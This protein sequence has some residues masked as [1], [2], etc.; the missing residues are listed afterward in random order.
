MFV[1]AIIAAAVTAFS[2]TCAYDLPDEKTLLS[3]FSQDSCPDGWKCGSVL[4]V[5]STDYCPG[6]EGG[7][8]INLA[9]GQV[10]RTAPTSENIPFSCNYHPQPPMALFTHC[11]KFS[12]T[13]GDTLC[14]QNQKCAYWDKPGS[15]QTTLFCLDPNKILANT[16]DCPNGCTT[17]TCYTVFEPASDKEA[18]YQTCSTQLT[19]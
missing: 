5:S 13:C 3:C 19:P 1:R 4:T 18:S 9:N 16:K 8:F 6:S 14:G 15:T 17:G 12:P 2:A 7:G 11:Y 10:T